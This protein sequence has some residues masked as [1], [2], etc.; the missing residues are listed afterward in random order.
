MNS[1]VLAKVVGGQVLQSLK[2]AAVFGVLPGWWS[3][4]VSCEQW[5]LK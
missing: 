3:Q 1:S 5:I 2:M 4:Y